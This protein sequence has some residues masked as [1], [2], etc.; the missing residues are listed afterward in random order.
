V[1]APT[2]AAQEEALDLLCT[3]STALKSRS[4]IQT[5]TSRATKITIRRAEIRLHVNSA[6]P[7]GGELI[8]H[9]AIREAQ[10]T[11]KSPITSLLAGDKIALK[12]GLFDKIPI[13]GYKS[14][15]QE[16]PSWMKIG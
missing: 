1:E 8:V 3:F 14:F 7:A 6:A 11:R 16:E 15:E 2:A 10:L 9:V 5:T 12:G 13:P 4:T